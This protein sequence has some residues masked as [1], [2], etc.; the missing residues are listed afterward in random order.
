MLVSDWKEEC[1]RIINQGNGVWH[2]LTN[3]MGVGASLPSIHR[4]TMHLCKSHA[5]SQSLQGVPPERLFIDARSQ[6]TRSTMKRLPVAERPNRHVGRAT[7][8]VR[9]KATSKNNRSTPLP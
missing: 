2:A 8:R 4:R 3:G 9:G 1:P 7:R 6:W 5:L